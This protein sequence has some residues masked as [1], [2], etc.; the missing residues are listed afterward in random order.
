M[1]RSVWRRK[2]P[3]TSI[4]VLLMR[5]I[6][7]IVELV[8]RVN[9]SDPIRILKSGIDRSR[10]WH[11]RINRSHRTSRMRQCVKHL[12]RVMVT[13]LLLPPCQWW[14]PSLILIHFGHLDFHVQSWL[15]IKYLLTFLSFVVDV[16]NERKENYDVEKL[17]IISFCLLF[18]FLKIWEK[19][20]L[21]VAL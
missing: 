19:V 1:K 16:E 20:A 21:F 4:R 6:E 5:K 9:T 11:V 10:I 14:H 12:V 13:C 3:E 2:L 17:V 8:E 18:R 7:G 15:F